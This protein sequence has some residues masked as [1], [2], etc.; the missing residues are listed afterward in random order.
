MEYGLARVPMW[1]QQ[2]P[3]GP[4]QGV[5]SLRVPGPRGH[6]QANGPPLRR[7]FHLAGLCAVD[8]PSRP[9]AWRADFAELGSR[10]QE[11]TGHFQKR[12]SPG[13][14]K[15]ERSANGERRACNC[16]FAINPR[17]DS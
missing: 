6:K 14:V 17:L 9:G 1:G 11:P 13:L 8:H 2:Q 3:G 4:D 5:R 15:R 12:G 16:H 10:G 7:L